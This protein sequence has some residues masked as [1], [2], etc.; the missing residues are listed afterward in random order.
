[1]ESAKAAR[2]LWLNYPNN[3]TGGVASLEFFAEAVEFCRQ[4]EILLCH[5]APYTDVTFDGYRASSVLEIPGA[6]E[7]AIEFNSLSKTYNM[8]GWRVGM[9]V[10]CQVAVEALASVKTQTDSGIA[11]P[12]QD[13]AAHALTA[14]QGWLNERNAIYQERRDLTL[15]TLDKMGLETTFPKGAFYI[16]FRVPAGYTS[17]QFQSLVLEKAHVSITP[18][19]IYGVNGEGWARISLV[20][21]TER[22]KEALARLEAVI[23]S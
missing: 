1:V 11:K 16:W 12:I 22:L 9:A 8:A 14:D 3:P 15:A 19:S 23:N 13:M 6:K 20:A 17:E 21:K 18:G 7:V 2:M 5:D 10:G 4:Y